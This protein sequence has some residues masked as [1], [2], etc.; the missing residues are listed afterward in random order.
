MANN[1]P[2]NL[3]GWAKEFY[4]N[5]QKLGSNPS[6]TDIKGNTSALSDL[7]NMTYGTSGLSLFRLFTDYR[8]DPNAK[9]DIYGNV[10][11]PNSIYGVRSETPSMPATPDYDDLPVGMSYSEALARAQRRLNPQYDAMRSKLEQ[12]YSQQRADT[13]SYW[14]R[15]MAAFL[16]LVAAGGRRQNTAPPNKRLK[17]SLKQKHR[18]RQL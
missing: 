6:L 8:A 12:T 9:S 1:N 14:R 11:N 4:D 5:Y 10:V 13:L 18:A 16:A 3:T 15:D 2:R 7:T 17:Q